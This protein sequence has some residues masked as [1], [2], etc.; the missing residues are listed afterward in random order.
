VGQYFV[1]I[2]RINGEKV[3]PKLELGKTSGQL[4]MKIMASI[5]PAFEGVKNDELTADEFIMQA[6]STQLQTIGQDTI[7]EQTD[8]II[9]NQYGEG[10][11][12]SQEQRNFIKNQVE[13]KSLK[14]QESLSESN[15]SLILREGRKQLSQMTGQ[16]IVGNEKM[17]DI[18]SGLMNKKVNNYLAP[19]IESP[20]REKILP[21]IL[22][23]FLFFTLWPIGS[24]LGFFCIRFF[25]LL[26]YILRK[27]SILVVK[28]VM[29]EMEVIE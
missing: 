14:M 11:D 21:I 5:N 12:I 23:F 20:G 19:S 22:A 10:K 3:L 2:Q 17:Y 9:K 28:K 15:K 6:Q 7:D 1:T 29:V 8:F 26:M 13:E 25:A 4:V 18:F 16:E 27:T 24:L